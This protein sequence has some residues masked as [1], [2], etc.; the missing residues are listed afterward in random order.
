MPTNLSRAQIVREDEGAINRRIVARVAKADYRR[1]EAASIKMMARFTSAEGKRLFLRYFSS[2][3]LH[4]HFISVIAR[5]RLEAAEVE[6]VEEAIRSR[7]NAA[8]QSINDAI[9]AAEALF[10]AHGITTAATYDTEALEIEAAI[11]S[12]FGRRYLETISK[13]DQLMPLLQTL[14]IHE[15]ATHQ[16]LEIQRALLKRQVRDIAHAARGIANGLRRRLNVQAQ[17]SAA[18]PL[19]GEEAIIESADDEGNDGSVITGAAETVIVQQASEESQKE[20]A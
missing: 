9:D 3:Q 6:A 13:L 10:Q 4:M 11:I 8:T 18:A 17:E 20:T 2:L 7:L 5:L 14:E 12:S 15:I 16:S 19:A 1:I